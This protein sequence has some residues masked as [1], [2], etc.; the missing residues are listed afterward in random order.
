MVVDIVIVTF[1]V[2]GDGL[3][4]GQRLS[5]LLNGDGDVTI[6]TRLSPDGTPPPPPPTH[7]PNET[8]TYH[9]AFLLVLTQAQAQAHARVFC[10]G[11]LRG[12]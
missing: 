11:S 7:T 2:T 3:Q 1:M 5:L 8:D 6:Q 4:I 12:R 10:R 9:N